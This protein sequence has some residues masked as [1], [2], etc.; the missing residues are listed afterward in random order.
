MKHSKICWCFFLWAFCFVGPVGKGGGKN[1]V[2]G[3]FWKNRV[4][5]RQGI[6]PH[7]LAAAIKRGA[8]PAHAF[9]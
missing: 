4:G 9:A 3:G 5:G 2:G 7:R 1:G 8:A 6:V